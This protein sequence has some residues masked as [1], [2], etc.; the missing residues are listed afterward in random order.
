MG[1]TIM[2]IIKIDGSTLT[3][4]SSASDITDVTTTSAL[5]EGSNLYYTEARVNAN[6]ATKTTTDLTEG[7]NL[8]YTDVR[9]DGRVNLQTGANL[10]LSSKTTTDLT[11]GSNLYYTDVRAVDAV[12]A[13][14]LL[15]LN[16]LNT[17]AVTTDSSLFEFNTSVESFNNAFTVGGNY[18][19]LIDQL[20]IETNSGR[21]NRSRSAMRATANADFDSGAGLE[22]FSNEFGVDTSYSLN[23]SEIANI[24]V[25]VEDPDFDT[26]NTLMYGNG[27]SAFFNVQMRGDGYVPGSGPP[28]QALKIEPWS[29]RIT[30]NTASGTA[31]LTIETNAPAIEDTKPHVFVNLTTTERNALTAESGMMI[32]NTTDVKLQCYDGSAWNNLH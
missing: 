22:Q 7:S 32:F 27:Q 13:T 20:R 16:D 14:S 1:N 25:Q 30:M 18:D 24:G 12:E 4:H 29:S 3:S 2:A 26:D 31:N 10:D 6:F 8:Y 21:W 15:T 28:L 19:S 5:A 23:N 17:S 9:T 11:E